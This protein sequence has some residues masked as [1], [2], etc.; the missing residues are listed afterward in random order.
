MGLDP[1]WVLS[2][3]VS[4]LGW[5]LGWACLLWEGE[6]TQ[7][8]TAPEEGPFKWVWWSTPVILT[9]QEAET[10]GLL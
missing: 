7:R 5:S 6:Q 2:F 9:P 1:A 10:D 3:P 8:N 4:H